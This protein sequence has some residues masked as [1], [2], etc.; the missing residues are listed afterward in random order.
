MSENEAPML[1]LSNFESYRLTNRQT[2]TTGVRSNYIP[3]RFVG[4]RRI[5]Y[6]T[7]ECRTRDGHET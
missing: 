3:R 7:Y 2:D 6:P 5:Q 4:G 1:R